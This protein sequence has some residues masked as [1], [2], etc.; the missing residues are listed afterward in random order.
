MFPIDERDLID[1]V[2]KI[3]YQT[4]PTPQ[5]P[6]PKAGARVGFSGNFAKKREVILDVT[7]DRGILGA[8]AD[9]CNLAIEALDE[10]SSLIL[11]EFK[12]D[13]TKTSRFYEIN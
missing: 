3:G 4:L 2:K 8:S 9:S 11:N 6:P 7:T 13:I 10:L 5:F 12:V 1:S